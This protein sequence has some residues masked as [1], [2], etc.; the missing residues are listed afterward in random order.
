MDKTYKVSEVAEI[1]GIDD[2]VVR[3]ACHARRQTFAT[4]LKPNGRFYIDLDKFRAWWDRR[5]AET[6][7]NRGY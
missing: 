4:R 6:S 2:R 5:Q 1:F 7:E 3:D